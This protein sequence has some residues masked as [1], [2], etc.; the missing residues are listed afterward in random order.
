MIVNEVNCSFAHQYAV[1]RMGQQASRVGKV[2]SRIRRQVLWAQV[3][4][5]AATQQP[6][7]LQQCTP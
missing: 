2:L 7:A 3:C 5:A 4:E 6:E 1:D